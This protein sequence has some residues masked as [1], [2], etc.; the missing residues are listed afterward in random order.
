MYK[1]FLFLTVCLFASVLALSAILLTVFEEKPRISRRVILTP[2][3][4]KRAKQIID[5]HRYR[6]RPGMIAVAKVLSE[7]ADLA[8]NYLVS[9]FVKGSA[10][11]TLANHSAHVL[12]SIP[13]PGNPL[14]AYLNLEATLIETEG[15]LQPRS[16]H[17]GKLALPDF[18]TDM[19]MSQL[20]RWLRQ[21]PEY[22]LGLDALQK[23]RI[24]RSELN[25][26]YHWK[27]GFYQE[28]RASIVSEKEREQLFFY[29]SLLIENSRRG[30]TTA[31]SLAEILPPFLGLAAERS[32]TGNALAENRAAILVVTFYTLERSLKSLIPEAAAWPSPVR[33]TVTVSGRNDFAKHFMISATIAAYADTALSDAVGL[34]KEIE[35]S[36][37]GSGFSFNDI[38]ADRAG[39][40]FGEKA[41]ASIDLAQQ[42]QQR[43]ASGLRDSDL[44]PPWS[45]LPE[46]MPEG[47]FKRRFGGI[48]T[49]AYQQMI[50]EIDQRVSILGVLH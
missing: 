35:D 16:V 34:Y 7:D 9:R 29:H 50:Q 39:T 25:V 43:V 18:L 45:D 27:G 10:Q 3:H 1:F 47:E 24:S 6:V 13:T 30:V 42:L 48:G 5:V 23:I 20:I 37:T 14:G 8:A 21:S 46:F 17:V 28:M 40:R 12:L 4:I 36:R 44:M 2:E 33:R 22:R 15:M 26:T 19:F 11:V 49:P 32:V 41:V 31:V 38:A